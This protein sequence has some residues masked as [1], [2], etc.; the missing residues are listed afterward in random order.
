MLADANLQSANAGAQEQTRHEQRPDR[1]PRPERGNRSSRGGERNEGGERGEPRPESTPAVDASNENL[2][3]DGSTREP[4]E[5]REGRGGRG[6]RNGRAPRSD[7]EARNASGEG[8]QSQLGFADGDNSP[9]KASADQPA[10]NDDSG[11]VTARSE[12]SDPRE[13]RNRDRY[14]RERGPRGEREE[15]PD[16]RIP[17]QPV[18]AQAGDAEAA[19][20]TEP[21][22]APAP[23]MADVAATAVAPVA[24]ATVAPG[25]AAPSARMPKV[26]TFALP[27][28]AL[29]TVAQGSGLQW[30]NSDADKVAAV[31]AAIAAESKPVHV[32]RERPAA[33]AIDAGPLVMVE[34]KRDLR[35]MALPFEQTPA[36]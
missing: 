32:P 1:G 22:Q 14:G 5:P 11:S 21:V 36:A 16:L 23:R 10:P 33:V 8:R 27:T 4:R 25:T 6:G 2:N 20:V 13:K 35:D 19:P 26:T 12:N 24:P 3:N 9:E 18:A 31:Q 7:S 15:R 28:D 30:V 34:T 29:L 17:A